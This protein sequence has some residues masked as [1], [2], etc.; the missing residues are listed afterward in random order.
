MDDA[1]AS[2]FS[3]LARVVCVCF[4]EAIK[5]ALLRFLCNSQR[6]ITD[7]CYTRFGRTREWSQDLTVVDVNTTQEHWP[8]QALT[9]PIISKKTENSQIF[10]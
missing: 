1:L 3:E 10:N 5:P 8:L 9:E 7:K 4:F 6:A 2:E